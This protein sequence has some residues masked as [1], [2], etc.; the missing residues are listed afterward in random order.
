MN[1]L[2]TD[3]SETS[4]RMIKF[5]VNSSLSSDDLIQAMNQLN[6]FRNDCSES[7]QAFMDFYFNLKLEQM[8]NENDIN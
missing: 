2:F 6:K 3:I 1:E 4:K 7:E 5:I 8:K